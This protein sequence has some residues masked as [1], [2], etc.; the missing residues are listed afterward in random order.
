M[1]K[2]HVSKRK[3]TCRI[4]KEHISR[5]IS[6]SINLVIER[7]KG[8][9][10]YDVQG[11]KYLDFSSG[12]GVTSLGENSFFFC[13]A[14]SCM[15]SYFHIVPK[16]VKAAQ[17]QAAKLNHA[18]VNIG[19]HKPM[20][21]LIGK[22]KPVM[23][24]TQFDSFFFRNSGAEAVEAAIKLARGYHGRTVGTMSLTTSKAIYRGR[25]GPLMPGVHVAPFPYC[26][27]CP[28]HR[29]VPQKHNVINCCDNPIEQV[30]LL[31]KQQTTPD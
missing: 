25:F 23:P 5:G 14:K 7:A 1:F 24:S 21:D 8:S 27:T 9:Y 3:A 12:I 6:R 19:F 18:Q 31:L 4:W 2:R 30:K 11:K 20:L 16:V 29:A 28:V 10:L 22:L 13:L 26:F 15:E 17:E